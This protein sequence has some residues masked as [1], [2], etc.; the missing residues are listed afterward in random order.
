M[1]VALG[2]LLMSLPF[3]ALAGEKIIGVGLVL[4]QENFKTFVQQIIPNLPAQ[5]DG[6]VK[7]ADE[8]VGVRPFRGDDQEYV[9]VEGLSLDQVVQLIRGETPTLVGLEMANKDGRYE[10]YLIRQE[11]EIPDHP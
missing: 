3:S 5:K 4:K 6:T 1:K 11:F 2:L 10:V 7:V 8:V 9:P